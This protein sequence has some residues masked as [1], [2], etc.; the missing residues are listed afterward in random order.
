M[1]DGTIEINN[2][3]LGGDSIKQ[4]IS[5]SNL[6]N[7]YQYSADMIDGNTGTTPFTESYLLKE[8]DFFLLNEDGSFLVINRGI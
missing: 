1:P 2:N 3:A 5:A 8:D 7:D 4:E 6:V